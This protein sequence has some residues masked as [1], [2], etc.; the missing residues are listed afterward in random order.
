MQNKIFNDVL[1][2]EII[3]FSIVLCHILLGIKNVFVV[4]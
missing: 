3:S 1:T 2:V 4:W